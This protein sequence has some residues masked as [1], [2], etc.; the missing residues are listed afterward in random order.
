VAVDLGLAAAAIGTET[1]GS[2]TNP[3]SRNGVV[4]IKPT[5]GLTSRDLVIPIS[6]HQDSVGPMT[7]SV[8]DAALLLQALAGR[9]E[10]DAYSLDIPSVPDYVGACKTDSLQ[11]AR[12]GV[13]SH[14]LKDNYETGEFRKALDGMT[15][16]GA[17]IVECEFTTT[18]KDLRKAEFQVFAA[19]FVPGLGAYLAQLA[20]NPS[21]IRS[22][23]D[24]RDM[25]VQHG[26][27]EDYPARDVD[28]WEE[29][30]AQGWDNSS[31]EFEKVYAELLEMGGTGALLGC[32]E[33]LGLS[34]V[35]LPTSIAPPWAA[36]VG[37]PIITVPL[38]H[39][40]A[41]EEVSM[42]NG[43]VDTGPGVPFG[44]SFLGPK[45]SEQRLIGLAYAFEQST[46]VR[47]R[48]VKRV[49]EP[50]AALHCKSE[51]GA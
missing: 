7:R 40:P 17:T 26:G 48:A 51:G 43:L 20:H 3:A 38:G 16:L 35:V 47:G 36:V 21:G 31:P 12:L 25:T 30:L 24:V 22:L 8:R 10:R 2:I 32:I 41:D 34:A 15:A 1:D 27:E 42:E 19:D 6:E 5:V 14:L 39:Y 23:R 49:V 28:R 18:K 33:R 46:R 11:G 9:D 13:P 37:A 45:Y 29:V 44:M 50:Q 4:G